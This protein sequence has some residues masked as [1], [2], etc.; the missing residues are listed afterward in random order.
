MVCRRAST[1]MTTNGVYFQTLSMMVESIAMPG[2]RAS[3]CCSRIE[4]APRSAQF[5]TPMSG[6]NIQRQMSA[7]T[8]VGT[9]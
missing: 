1:Q 6:L 7:M 8:T 9:M 2:A 3:R 5:T 4:P